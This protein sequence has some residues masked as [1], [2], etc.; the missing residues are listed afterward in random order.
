MATNNA[1]TKEFVF[2]LF[3]TAVAMAGVIALAASLAPK[4]FKSQT[5]ATTAS[6]STVA[7]NTNRR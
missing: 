6:T 3:I 2:Y 1:N 7:D 5:Q 4:V